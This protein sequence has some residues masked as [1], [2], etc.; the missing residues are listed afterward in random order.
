MESGGL[1]YTGSQRVRNDLLAEQQQIG[2]L[3]SLFIFLLPHSGF[4]CQRW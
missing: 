2:M 3:V 4:L 1:Q